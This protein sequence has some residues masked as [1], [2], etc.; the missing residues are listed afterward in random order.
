MEYQAKMAYKVDIARLQTKTPFWEGLLVGK[1]RIAARFPLLVVIVSNRREIQN[2]RSV[3]CLGAMTGVEG[4]LIS[5]SEYFERILA[6]MVI[7]DLAA[8]FLVNKAFNQVVSRVQ[9]KLRLN[10]VWV[11]GWFVV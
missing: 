1:R 11:C 10:V 4:N 2:R 9:Y 5:I 3:N 6:N 8:I 7:A